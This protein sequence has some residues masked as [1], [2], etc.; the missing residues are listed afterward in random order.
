[1]YEDL[2]MEISEGNIDCWELYLPGQWIPH[3]GLLI[4]DNEK[5]IAI[6]VE[7]LLQNHPPGGTLSSIGVCGF[8][9]KFEIELREGSESYA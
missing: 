1:M 8:D 4:D 6:G 7:H 2:H 9:Q 3:C 5:Q